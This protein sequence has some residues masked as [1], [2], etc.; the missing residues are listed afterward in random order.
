MTDEDNRRKMSSLVAAILARLPQNR[1]YYL[2]SESPFEIDRAPTFKAGGSLLS[3]QCFFNLPLG[4]FYDAMVNTKL[5][6]VQ[7]NRSKKG[8]WGNAIW[9]KDDTNWHNFFD[10][11]Y[12]GLLS[13]SSYTSITLL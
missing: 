4:Q 7:K 2:P 8:E 13:P 11:H 9:N 3:L 10:Q 6:R 5:V 12:E 1:E